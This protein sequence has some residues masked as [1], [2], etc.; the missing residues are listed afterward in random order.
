MVTTSH[1]P[2]AVIKASLAMS[3]TSQT[4][5]SPCGHGGGERLSQEQNEKEVPLSR[6]NRPG[7]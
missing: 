7:M 6:F 4:R 3:A 1:P 5:A 2:A